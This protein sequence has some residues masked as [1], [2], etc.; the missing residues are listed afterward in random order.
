MLVELRVL[1]QFLP[2]WNLAVLNDC[3]FLAL[4]PQNSQLLINRF[5][6][7]LLSLVVGEFTGLENST[8]L[9]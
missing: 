7:L 5:Q 4:H 8:L 6:L 9:V 1:R 3:P 2:K